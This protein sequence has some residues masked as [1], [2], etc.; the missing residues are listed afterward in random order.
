MSSSKRRRNANDLLANAEKTELFRALSAGIGVKFANSSGGNSDAGNNSRNAHLFRQMMHGSGGGGRVNGEQDEDDYVESSG[1]MLMSTFDP[2]LERVATNDDDD[3]EGG[4]EKKESRTGAISRFLP[5]RDLDFFGDM[6][7]AV[8]VEEEE[9]MEE[10]EEDQKSCGSDEEM[11]SDVDDDSENE[12]DDEDSLISRLTRVEYTKRTE[13]QIRHVRQEYRIYI[14][15]VDC[16]NP[17]VSF[18]ELAKRPFAMNSALLKNIATGHKFTEPTPVQMQTI[19]ILTRGREVLVSASTGSGKTMAFAVPILHSLKTP[20]EE[21]FRALVI[22]PTKVLAEQIYSDMLILGDGMGWK[23][24]CVDRQTDND[25]ALRSKRNDVL[26]TTPTWLVRMIQD[27][28]IDVSKYVLH[29]VWCRM[30]DV[31]TD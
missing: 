29:V 21:G 17:I 12:E 14:K 30:R 6:K 22:T 24:R 5:V 25:E 19:P 20:A 1:D 8:V 11:D 3:D 2:V 28:I 13:E 23:I 15:G 27:K 31:R 9:E 7:E 16:P 26:I 18:G 4:D 10:E